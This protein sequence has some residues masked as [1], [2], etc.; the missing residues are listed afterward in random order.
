MEI[1]RYKNFKRSIDI[2]SIKYGLSFDDVLIVPRFS[3]IPSRSLVN[4]STKLTK[5]L[6]IDIPIISANMDTV[7]ETNMA[8]TM[9]KCGAVG[10][11]HRFC[12]IEEQ[13]KMILDTWMTSETD[14]QVGAAVGVEDYRDR[15]PAL[16][17]AG[18][19]FTVLDIAHGHASSAIEAIKYIKDKF[20]IQVVAGNVATAN[21]FRDLAEAGADAVKVGIG[22]GAA[23]T[24][25]LVAGVGVPQLSAIIDCAQVSQEYG[26]PLIA[27]GGIKN[28]GDIA[29]AIVAGAD[30]VM[31]GSLLAGTNEAPGEAF[32]SDEHQM[33][34]KEYRG[35]AS[36]EVQDELGRDRKH[37]EGVSGFVKYSGFVADIVNNLVGGL[38]SSMSYV[39]TDNISDFRVKAKFVRITSAGL[40]ESQPHDIIL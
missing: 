17:N 16:Y 8:Q 20:D 4:V 6:V 14:V 31:I 18:T 33:L 37:V 27:D 10:V 21:G 38:K 7:T 29:K 15:I 26:I 32:W 24:T 39:G 1:S 30:S 12:T 5:N 36:A 28:S 35:M 22:P 11:I 13:S 9:D 40:R 34:I 19:S 3:D 25:R 2:E 23:C